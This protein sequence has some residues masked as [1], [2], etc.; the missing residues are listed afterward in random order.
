MKTK[1]H[2]PTEQYGFIEIENEYE[3]FQ[4]ILEHQKKLSKMIEG[5]L[6]DKEWRKALD[7]YLTENTLNSEEYANM[8]SWQQLVVQE[9]KKSLK[10]INYDSKKEQ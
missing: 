9:I 8:S 10:R 3:N 1:I 2:I 7:K 5:G 6:T 4:E